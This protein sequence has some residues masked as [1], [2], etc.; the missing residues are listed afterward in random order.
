MTRSAPERRGSRPPPAAG[1]WS[2]ASVPRRAAAAASRRAQ[3]C[4]S[5]GARGEAG[6]AAGAP[7]AVQ[8]S[9]S[10]ARKKTCNGRRSGGGTKLVSRSRSRSRIAA[11]CRTPAST[12]A[13]AH[14]GSC[15]E[16]PFTAAA[17]PPRPSR[18]SGHT[19]RAPRRSPPLARRPSHES[20]SKKQRSLTVKTHPAREDASPGSVISTWSRQLLTHLLTC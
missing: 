8:L 1:G 12:L 5:G 13:P 19:R 6:A 20:W 15:E 18:R 4:W 9:A 10:E 17:R 3:L 14:S 11:S 16:A 7:A 2:A